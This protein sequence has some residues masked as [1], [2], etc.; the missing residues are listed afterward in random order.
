MAQVNLA[1][2]AEI[3]SAKRART[4]AAILDAARECYA[5][6]PV[7][8]DAVMQAAGLAK[9]TFYV[10]FEDLSALEAELGAELIAELDERLQPARLAASDPLTRLATATTIL[11]RYLA[12]KPARAR[13]AARAD[14]PGVSQAVLVR[15]RED[16]TAAL[17]AGHVALPSTDLAARIVSA[18]SFQA[19]RD[20]GLAQ[21]DASTV[22]HVVGAILR[23]I[24]CTPDDAAA[25]TAE[26]ARN[27]DTFAHQLAAAGE[28]D[29]PGG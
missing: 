23:A 5:A 25:R 2:R 27:A 4:R 18:I 11:L 9:G 26:A 29:L 7:T 1:R 21:I 8:V 13:L 6:G 3:G 17:A 28:A 20:L 22:P 19:A 16:L 15:L 24:G 14:I 12:A 10:H